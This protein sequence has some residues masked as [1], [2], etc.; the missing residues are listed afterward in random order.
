MFR[1]TPTPVQIELALG[2]R[3]PNRVSFDGSVIRVER[4]ATSQTSTARS[5]ENWL[6]KQVREAINREL[7]G[8][9]QKLRRT[10]HRVYV[11]GQRT[12]WGNC[13]SLENLSFSW[14]LIMLPEY[15]F[16]YLVTH[17]A[18]HMV[19]PDHS[20]RFWLTVQSLCP[21][22]ERAKQWLT[23]YGASLPLG[24]DEVVL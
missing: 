20:V 17:E 24:L 8:V 5:L 22:T 7:T 19:V 21:E 16:R 14:R 13:S 2:R 18:V 11:M 23:R 3:G 12:K 9:T 4:S 10:P 15:V 1:G 6:R